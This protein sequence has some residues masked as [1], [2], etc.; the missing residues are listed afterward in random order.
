MR[1][2]NVVDL[3]QYR[4]PR[5]RTRRVEATVASVCA[6]LLIAAWLA[7]VAYACGCA[8]PASYLG[9]P[10]ACAHSGQVA[11]S[12]YGERCECAPRALRAPPLR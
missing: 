1:R 5:P 11:V 8:G 10:A 3:A 6:A 12:R 7:C 2:D 4:A 9:C